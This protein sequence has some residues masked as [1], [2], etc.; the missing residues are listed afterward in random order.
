MIFLGITGLLR[1][2]TTGI[3]IAGDLN[4]ISATADYLNNPIGMVFDSS[5][6]LYVTDSNNHRIQQFSPG[7][8][9]GKTVA[10]QSNGIFGLIADRLNVPNDVAID[11]NGNL[12]VVDTSNHRVQLWLANATSGITIAGSGQYISNIEM[13]LLYFSISL[14]RIGRKF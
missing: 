13:I 14:Y 4:A 1:W 10:G 11:S 6:I 9:T 8:M 3:T 12:Y 5:D 7:N 2:N